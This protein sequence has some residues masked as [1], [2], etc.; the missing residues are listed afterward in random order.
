MRN[1][2]NGNTCNPGSKVKFVVV[3]DDAKIDHEK[4]ILDEE[5]GFEQNKYKR[6]ISIIIARLQSRRNLVRIST[7]WLG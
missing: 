3:N 5:I 6:G 7:F 4:V 2:M 1:H